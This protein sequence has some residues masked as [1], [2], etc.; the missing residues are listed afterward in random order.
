MSCE[1][2]L[3]KY[4]KQVKLNYHFDDNVSYGKIQPITSKKDYSENMKEMKYGDMI[5]EKLINQLSKGLR[6]KVDLSN[7]INCIYDQKNMDIS[8]SCCIAYCLTIRANYINNQRYRITKMIFGNKII[9]INPSILY[10]NWNAHIQDL[11]VK[12]TP[13]SI[14][15]HLI[16]LQN[17]KI[18]DVSKYEDSPDKLESKPDLNSFYYASKS[19]DVKWYKI[20]QDEITLKILLSDGHPIIC[21]IVVYKDMLS[22]I[23]YQFGIIKT[24]DYENESSCGCHVITIIGYNDSKKIFYFVNSWSEKWGDKGIGEIGYD[25]VLNKGLC[26]DFAI[27]DYSLM[28]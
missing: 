11:T 26:G 23:A 6:Q 9:P 22:L 10:L 3:L 13:L 2:D 14:Y 25:Y 8:I 7:F 12:R 5:D 17:H 19:P 1:E 16:S 15:S 24:P 27:L 21:G 18:V 28:N 4:F 20:R